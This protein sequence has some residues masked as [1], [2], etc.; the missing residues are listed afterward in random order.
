VY[1]PASSQVE[2]L[3]METSAAAAKLK[4]RLF[5]ETNEIHWAEEKAH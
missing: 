2:A 1:D 4:R 3:L 5:P